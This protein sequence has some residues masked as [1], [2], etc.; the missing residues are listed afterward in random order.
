MHQSMLSGRRS[1]LVTG[2]T[3][4]LRSDPAPDART[5]A[6]IE[7]RVVGYLMACTDAWCRVEIADRKGWLPRAALWGVYPGETIK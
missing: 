3:Q 2:K 4:A 7:P 1:V 5:I 6:Q